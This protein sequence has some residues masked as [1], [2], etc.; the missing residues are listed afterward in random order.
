MSS[1]DSFNFMSSSGESLAK[2]LHVLF[3]RSSMISKIATKAKTSSSLS[4]TEATASL[5]FDAV[6]AYGGRKS[7]STHQGL[8]PCPGG[9]LVPGASSLNIGKALRGEPAAAVHG[10]RPQTP[11][12][13]TMLTQLLQHTSAGKSVSKLVFSPALIRDSNPSCTDHTRL[14]LCC[15]C[16]EGYYRGNYK[17]NLSCVWA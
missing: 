16:G 4:I 3:K 12:Q 1:S 8:I 17:R 2:I 14:L 15:Q 7:Y 6:G 11:P 9:V 5:M 13:V 10:I